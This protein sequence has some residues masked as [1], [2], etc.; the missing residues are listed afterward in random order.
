[1]SFDFA[2]VESGVLRLKINSKD[3]L[4]LDDEAYLVVRPMQKTKVL[5]VTPGNEPL[6]IA[7]STKTAQEVAE[8]Q[9]ESPEFLKDEKKYTI[10][11]SR[12]FTIW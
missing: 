12:A 2:A 11:G 1:M 7:V 9:I 3:D 6:T 4:K 5:L 8:V 10:P